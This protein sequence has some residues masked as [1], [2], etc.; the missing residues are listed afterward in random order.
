MSRRLS[1]M[2]T[3]EARLAAKKAADGLREYAR[4][5]H[6]GMPTLEDVEKLMMALSAAKFDLSLLGM[7]PL[8]RIEAREKRAKKMNTAASE[9]RAPRPP[10]KLPALKVPASPPEQDL[11]WQK[12]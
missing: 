7:P 4:A 5:H 10:P 2:E 11:W 12:Y 3:V 9:S 8:E 6:G 1:Q